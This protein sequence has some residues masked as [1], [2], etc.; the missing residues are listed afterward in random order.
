VQVVGI[1]RDLIDVGPRRSMP[2]STSG[3]PLIGNIA[4]GWC[5][6]AA[7]AARSPGGQHNAYDLNRNSA[8][9][10]STRA[11]SRRRDRGDLASVGS[12]ST[13]ANATSRARATRSC[14]AQRRQ[15]QI[16]AAFLRVR[17]SCP[18]PGL[19]VDL[20]QLEPVGR[21]LDGSSRCSLSG[22]PP[23]Q[24]IAERLVRS[25]RPGPAT[26]AAA[27]RRTGPPT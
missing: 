13:T 19:E 7:A 23:R 20:S 18:R 26:G 12:S 3:T 16:G 21:A 25:R 2:R 10:S 1:D 4:F 14:R 17:G 6:S 24:Q 5:R 8:S 22:V 11:G 9:S 27:Q 15:L